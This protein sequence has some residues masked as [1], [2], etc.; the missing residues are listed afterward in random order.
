MLFFEHRLSSP[1]FI[2]FLGFLISC[3]PRI[4][5]DSIITSRIE[6]KDFVDIVTVSGTL[7]AINTHS[8]CC[9]GIWSDVTIQYL[10]PEGTNVTSRDTMCILECREIK[11]EYLLAINELEKA[12]SEYK[13]STADLV[14]RYLLLEAQVK[15]IEASTEITRLDSVQMNFTTPSSREIIRLELQKAEL[16]KNIT[17]M[18]LEFL[19]QINKAELQKMQLKIKQQENR[20]DQA[21]TKL[22]RLTLTSNIDGIVIYCKNWEGIKLREGDITWGNMPIIEI[23]DLSAMQVKLDV[24]EAE[25]KR[26]ANDQSLEIV[27]DAFPDIELTGKIKYKAPVGKP[28]KKNSDVKVFEVIVTLDSSSMNL[29]PGLG[30]TCE[31][32]VKNVPD[33]VVVPLVALF[34]ED[35]LRVVYVADKQMFNR[36]AVVVAYYNNKEAIIEEGLEGYETL[37]LMKPPESLINYTES[38]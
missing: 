21:K 8:Y 12:Q 16:E 3:S 20:V 14:L 32:L 38:K 9:P 25:Y 6:K 37:A 18:K 36:M 5:F 11:N 22:D 19:K 23:P 2:L 15:T 30:L 26:L 13:K 27:V 10:I 17:L 34:D 7:E 24:C 29:Q 33:T 1:A 31:I 35:S 4:E 28:V